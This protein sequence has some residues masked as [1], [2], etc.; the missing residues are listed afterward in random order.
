MDAVSQIHFRVIFYLFTIYC[1]YIQSCA[2]G[3]T[4]QYACSGLDGALASNRRQDSRERGLS[5]HR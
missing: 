1:I 2:R 3:P 5:Y 4:V